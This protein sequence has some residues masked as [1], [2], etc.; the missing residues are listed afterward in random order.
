MQQKTRFAYHKNCIKICAILH[1][2]SQ[3]LLIT[4]I[5][6]KE[7]QLRLLFSIFTPDLIGTNSCSGKVKY[8]VWRI[9]VQ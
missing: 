8:K 2:R 6:E 5:V 4:K 9:S 3:D 1:S 7:N